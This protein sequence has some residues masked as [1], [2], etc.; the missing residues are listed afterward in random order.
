MPCC[1]HT[2]LVDKGKTMIPSDNKQTVSTDNNNNNRKE[3]N[4]NSRQDV[5]NQDSLTEQD[6]PESDN[7]STGAMGSGQRQDSN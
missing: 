4:K 6:L 7:E 1:W 5:Q 2:F 3:E